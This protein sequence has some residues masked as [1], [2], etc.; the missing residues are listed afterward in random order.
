MQTHLI[1]HQKLVQAVKNLRNNEAEI[2]DLIAQ[3]DQTKD[4]LM[5]MQYPSLFSYC[6]KGI[7]LTDAEAY[8]FLALYK[9]SKE[10]PALTEAIQSGAVSVSKL[11]HVCPVINQE[12]QKLW[13]EK[14]KSETNKKLIDEV[15]KVSPYTRKKEV[16]KPAGE[17]MKRLSLDVSPELMQTLLRLQEVLKLDNL[18]Q[19]IEVAANETLERKDPVKK[20]ERAETR[21]KKKEAL[22]QGKAAGKTSVKEDDEVVPKSSDKN[23]HDSEPVSRQERKNLSMHLVHAINRRD[24]GQCCYYGMSQKRCDSR[25]RVEIHHIT[26]VSRGGKDTIENLVTLCHDHHKL[27][28]ETFFSQGRNWTQI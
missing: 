27:I 22:E 5:L 21:A 17:G 1:I 28:H 15:A 2:L 26:P 8:N 10:I 18:T 9:K 12:N 16:V 20:A 24:R 25:H 14:A 19:V 3:A 6:V 4:F 11:R 7:G 23:D 13:I